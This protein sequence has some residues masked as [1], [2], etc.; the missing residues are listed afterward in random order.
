L[1]PELAGIPQ[2]LRFSYKVRLVQHPLQAKSVE[3]LLDMC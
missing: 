2:E 1:R 3:T